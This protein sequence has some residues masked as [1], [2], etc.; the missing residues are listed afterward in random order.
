MNVSKEARTKCVTTALIHA[1]KGANVAYSKSPSRC[2]RDESN[3]S[4][5]M[6]QC[7]T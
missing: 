2:M 4:N 6:Y 3:R 7:L 1:Q 5:I